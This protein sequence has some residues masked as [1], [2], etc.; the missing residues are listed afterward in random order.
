M[1]KTIKFTVSM[2][3][4]AFK[5]L[6]SLRLK[7]GWTRS[8]FIRESVR[9]WKAEFSETSGVKEDVGEYKKGISIDIIDPEEQ[10][11]RAIA[12]AGRF[13]S[14]IKDLSSHHDKHLGDAYSVV[15]PKRNKKK[16]K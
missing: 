2:P 9:T 6:E 5:E 16:T 13:R 1:S 8:Q 3:E 11:Q 10:R 14:G 7:T 12:A 15:A 4:V